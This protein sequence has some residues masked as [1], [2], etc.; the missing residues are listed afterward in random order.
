[1]KQR[2]ISK[3]PPN[4]VRQLVPILLTL[5]ISWYS[6]Q[7]AVAQ[8]S[9]QSINPVCSN[10]TLRAALEIINSACSEFSCEFEQLFALDQY[11]DKATFLTALRELRSNSVH[12][13]FPRGVSSAECS[14][15]WWSSKK[16]QLESLMQATETGDSTVFI[17]GRA[18]ITNFRGSSVETSTL[19]NRSLSAD[20]MDSIRRFLTEIKER[21]GQDC[22]F[23][24]GYFGREIMQLSK[25]DANFLLLDNAEYRDD[26]LV[27]NQSVH[28]LVYPCPLDLE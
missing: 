3:P 28:V 11:V 19:R 24:G 13:F 21:L 27:L 9:S 7:V 15:D 14:F 25:S 2:L 5:M 17:I 4:Y 12:I 6:G 20:R 1:M 16:S 23:K 26:A 8:A 18:S 10:D 22:S